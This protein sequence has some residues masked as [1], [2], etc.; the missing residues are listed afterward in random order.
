MASVN[1]MKLYG[2]TSSPY[3]RRIR[4][5]MEA[6]EYEFEQVAIHDAAEREAF[7]RISPLRKLPVLEDGNTVVFDSHVIYQHLVEY[8][9]LDPLS[10]HEAQL[11][12]AVDA[13]ADSLIILF[14]GEKSE[15]PV[16]ESRA[17]FRLQLGRIPPVLDW[18]EQQAKEGAFSPWS[19]PTMALISIM[20]WAEFRNLQSFERYPEL[21]AARASHQHREILAQTAPA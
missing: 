6:M 20:D 11:V 10:V 3:V 14:L 8:H 5:A 9:R 1:N 7:T 21:L 13:L 12:T 4:L 19:Y 2:S 16:D 15:L 17:L 18:L